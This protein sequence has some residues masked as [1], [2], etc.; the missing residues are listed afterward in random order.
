MQGPSKL[1]HC[2]VDDRRDGT[3][4]VLFKPMEIGS[5]CINVFYDETH[6]PG[7]WVGAWEII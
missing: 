2:E 6:V 7:G 3:Y 5:F 4:E 1:H